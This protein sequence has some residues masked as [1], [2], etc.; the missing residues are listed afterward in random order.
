MFEGD[1]DGGGVLVCPSWVFEKGGGTQ[2]NARVRFVVPPIGASVPM[3]S[4]FVRG[5]MNMMWKPSLM[6]TAR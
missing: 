1:G 5:S 2:T 3:H 6:G 4:R